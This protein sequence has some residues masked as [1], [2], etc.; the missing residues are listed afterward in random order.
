MIFLYHS[1]NLSTNSLTKSTNL[2]KRFFI[3]DNKLSFFLLLSSDF[4]SFP[5]ITAKTVDINIDGNVYSLYAYTKAL[6]GSPADISTMSLSI[7]N[8]NMIVLPID[9][10]VL[11]CPTKTRTYN[12]KLVKDGNNYGLAFI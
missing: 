9:Y 6:Y 7:N 12:C 10:F 2:L 8:G 3:I 1:F 11:S 5:G 4:V